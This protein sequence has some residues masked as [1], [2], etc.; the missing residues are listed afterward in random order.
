MK[1]TYIPEDIEKA[2]QNVWKKHNIFHINNNTNEKKFYCLSM[3]PYPSGKLHIGHIR[4][5]TI[6]DV[7]S[8]YKKLEGF[9]VLNPIGW[10]SFGIP[11][12]N[13]AYKNNISPDLWIQNNIKCMKGQLKKLGFGFDWDREF[14]TSHKDYYKWE[15]LFFTKLYKSNLIYK[16]DSFINWDPVDK[17]V[18]ANEQVIDGKGW[19]SNVEIERKK[20][21]QWYLKI[22]DYAD[23]LL[24]GL[25]N[26][27]KWPTKV[28]EMQKNWINRQVGYEVCFTIYKTDKVL[29]LLIENLTILKQL[30]FILISNEH[31][32]IDKSIT[33]AMYVIHP[34]NKKK[35]P[36]RITNKDH[37]YTTDY[38][39][40]AGISNNVLYESKAATGVL[41]NILSNY[42]VILIIKLLKNKIKKVCVYNLKDWCISR[43]RYWGA[44]IPIVYCDTCGVDTENEKKLPV[45]LPKIEQ[46]TYKNI[47]LNGIQEFV[48][49]SCSKCQ[50][51]ATREIETFDT[52]FESSWY[53]AKYIC[54]NENFKSSLLNTWLPVDQYIG[55]IEHATLHLIYARFFHKL[56]KDFNIV[57]CQEPFINLLTQGM[58]LMDGSKMS[59]SKGNIIDQELL[60]KTY[61]ADTL[62]LFILFSAPPEVSFEW[63]ENGIK[64]CRK[65][66]EKI[67]TLTHKV[68]ESQV[69]ENKVFEKLNFNTNQANI[70]NEFNKLLEKI[71]FNINETR[72]FNVVIAL[73]MTM[74]NLSEK[75]TSCDNL[76]AIILKK[77]TETILILLSPISPHI[78][79]YL[80]SDVLKN[81]TFIVNEKLP[82]KFKNVKLNDSMFDLAIQ[83]NNKFK[84]IITLNRN[85]DKNKIIDIATKND[86]IKN[87]LLNHT[88]KNI[89]YKDFKM[90]N[91][92]IDKNH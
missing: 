20:I 36:L 88:I 75:L 21:P 82:Q 9:N 44:P 85:S 10:D 25:Q 11:A 57:N 92:I 18:L 60:I 61:G 8:R 5:Y 1:K 89:I 37:Q 45:V 91:I 7:I 12:E 68:S 26:L 66:L 70:I 77:F 3:F 90:L 84:T 14:A 28:K 49:T 13:A 31:D 74:L 46:D 27:D 6:G 38:L 87:H 69:D 64:G 42:S 73:L 65:F 54:Y 63:K 40:D 71:Y 67:W 47:S 16:K 24:D 35:I 33:D 32:L 78:T 52:F 34:L 59:K 23:E 2:V 39:C 50:G 83:I 76:D 30:D 43:Q 58:V 29:K 22:T 53:Y 41:K 80:W 55:G 81:K 17:T 48:N 86:I 19:R 51:S 79:H 56:M 4:N 62:R 72:S 15:Q